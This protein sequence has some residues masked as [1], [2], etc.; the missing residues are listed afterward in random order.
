MSATE[1]VWLNRSFPSL[2]SELQSG[3]AHQ[4]RMMKHTFRLRQISGRL[5]DLSSATEERVL[6]TFSGFSGP[7]AQEVAVGCM[8]AQPPHRAYTRGTTR[9][10]L[11]HDNGLTETR[12]I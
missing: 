8:H 5:T 1:S 9:D 3:A 4:F 2:R 11:V 7:V 12:S 10:V 6:S